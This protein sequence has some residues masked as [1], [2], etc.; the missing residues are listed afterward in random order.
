MFLF[1]GEAKQ[2]PNFTDDYWLHIVA[3]VGL[4]AFT[5]N[6]FTESHTWNITTLKLGLMVT[7]SH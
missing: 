3:T 2:T 5:I 7:Q 6:S 4:A 1:T